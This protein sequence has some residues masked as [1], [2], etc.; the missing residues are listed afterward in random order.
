MSVLEQGDIIE[1]H[2]CVK[3]WESSAACTAFGNRTSTPP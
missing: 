1:V 2:G 3:S